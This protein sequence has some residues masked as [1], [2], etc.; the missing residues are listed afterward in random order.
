MRKKRHKLV[1]RQVE[2]F[3]KGVRL[4][5]KDRAAFEAFLDAVSQAYESSDAD[6][7]LLERSIEI[8]SKELLDANQELRVNSEKI[9]EHQAEMV[10]A[11]KMSE[12]GKMAGGL[13]HEIN[14][15]LAII[16]THA[17]LLADLCS[18]KS[19]D[20][21]AIASSAAEIEVTSKRIADIVS[22]LL[23]FSGDATGAP[24][25]R[26][27]IDQV[28]EGTVHLCAEKFRQ[29]AVEF[30]MNVPKGLDVFCRPTQLSQVLLNLLNNAYDAI[31][32]LSEKWISLDARDTGKG[33]IEVSVCDSGRGI[34]KD[35]QEKLFRPFFTTKQIGK[36]TG[37]GLSVSLGIVS[38]HNGSLQLDE[39]SQHTRFVIT[40]PKM[41]AST[42]KAA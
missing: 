6:R 31:E 30:S 14:T 12:L 28:V 40:L 25:S 11:S 42:K 18:E 13:A 8:S 9:R 38:E 10:A 17:G 24:F 26:T 39:T 22:A 23:A 20:L 15:P 4:I 5:G 33:T 37:L 29:Q 16:A 7:A 41:V 1:D 27:S 19:P 32:S 2:R 34:G 35:I 3:L 36:G 21:G